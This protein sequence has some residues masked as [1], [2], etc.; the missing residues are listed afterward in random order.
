MKRLVASI[1]LAAATLIGALQV[2]AAPLTAM[3]YIEIE[4]LY[5][6]YNH[7]IDS[8]DAKGYAYTFVEDGTFNNF[9]G[10]QQLIDFVTRYT[11][12]MN[13]AKR[14]HWNTNLRITG[15]SDGV[16]ASVYLMMLDLSTETTAISTSA[17]YN[18]TL[19]KTADGWRFKTRK[20]TSDR[21]R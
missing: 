5:A 8:G 1:S 3:D 4:Q 11:E 10:H 13:G 2:S 18:D 16:E 19:V 6:Q 12:K 15:D 17:K 20:T 21:P 9:K 7:A 14:R